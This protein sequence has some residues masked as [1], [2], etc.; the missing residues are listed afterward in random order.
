[1]GSGPHEQA[2]KAAADQSR[3]EIDFFGYCS[4]DKLKELIRK[5]K[6]VVLP[7]QWYENAPI[8]LLE[9]YACGKPVIGARIGG[10]PEM[11]L[12]GQTGLLYTSGD[13]NQLC[14][15]INQLETS[16]SSTL[17]EM[18]KFALNHVKNTYS[19]QRYRDNMLDL[20]ASL[21]VKTDRN[22]ISTH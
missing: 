10:I 5:A 22:T 18:G 14:E 16:P 7:S 19:L 9:A 8:S 12:E 4:G 20:Y 15:R 1:M 6:A 2:L 17:I 11:V 13:V 3:G 21:G